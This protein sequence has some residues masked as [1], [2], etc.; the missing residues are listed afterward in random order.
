MKRQVAWSFTILLPAVLLLAHPETRKVLLFD[1]YKLHHG[2]PYAVR[3]LSLPPEEKRILDALKTADE[4]QR[5]ELLERAYRETGQLWV[6]MLTLLAWS[7]ALG[8]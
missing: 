1:L 8:S 6:G 4:R 7:N 2:K 5:A 3:G